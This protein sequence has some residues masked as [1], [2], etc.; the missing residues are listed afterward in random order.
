[1]ADP[2]AVTITDDGVEDCSFTLYKNAAN[3]P[4]S[5]IFTNNA[6]SIA[7]WALATASSLLSD[8][9]P[10]NNSNPA[11]NSYPIA[12]DTGTLQLWVKSTAAVGT[13]VNKQYSI[14]VNGNELSCTTADPPDMQIDP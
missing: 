2:V 5:V 7:T 1:M 11:N 13:G 14:T 12:A 3:G 8:Q 4:D 10:P 6:T 9:A